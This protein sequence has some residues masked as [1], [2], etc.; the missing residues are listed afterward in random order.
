MDNL[1][2]AKQFDFGN[3]AESEP[4]IV[5]KRQIPI[6]I[7]DKKRFLGTINV[8]MVTYADGTAKLFDENGELRATG[9]PKN[10]KDKKNKRE[11]AEHDGRN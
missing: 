8:T 2:K 6:R 5:E 9:E 3:I 10:G 1:K 11:A 4:K 7:F